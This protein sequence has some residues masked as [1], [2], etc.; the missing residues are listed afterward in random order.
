MALVSFEC[1]RKFRIKTSKSVRL[2]GCCSALGELAKTKARTSKFAAQILKV[3]CSPAIINCVKCVLASLDSKK[4]CAF[5]RE[6]SRLDFIGEHTDR[7]SRFLP[8]DEHS[9]ESI[10]GLM[11]D[12]AHTFNEKALCSNL[13]EFDKGE[14][15]RVFGDEY[16]ANNGVLLSLSVFYCL[17]FG[18]CS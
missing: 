6:D 14:E 7:T 10:V 5:I 9:N 12:R 16:V 3:D 17:L 8:L 13:H 1:K 15:R 4:V 2:P 11:I 18:V